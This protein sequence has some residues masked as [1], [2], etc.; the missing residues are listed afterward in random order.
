MIPLPK[1]MTAQRAELFKLFGLKKNVSMSSKEI[2]E[3]IPHNLERNIE[4]IVSNNRMQGFIASIK[5]EGVA[6]YNLTDQGRYILK[7]LDQIVQTPMPPPTKYRPRGPA[8]APPAPKPKP[9]APNISGTANNLADYATALIDQNA[10]YRALLM[11]VYK[12]IG[13]ALIEDN[14]DGNSTTD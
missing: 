10:T 2:K 14:K 9:L 11:D 8:F 13:N 3:R 4:K 1:K 5:R 6:Y 7:N 12:L